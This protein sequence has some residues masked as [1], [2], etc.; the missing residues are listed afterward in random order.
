MSERSKSKLCLGSRTGRTESVAVRERDVHGA[1]QGLVDGTGPRRMQ[2][3]ERL[4]GK[5]NGFF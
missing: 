4:R 2:A 1:W 3:E 5:A